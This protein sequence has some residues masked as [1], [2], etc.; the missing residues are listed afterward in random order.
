MSTFRIFYYGCRRG[1]RGDTEAGHFLYGPEPELDRIPSRRTSLPFDLA[2]LDGTFAPTGGQ[3]QS[4][5]TVHVF[6]GWT[7]LSMWDR[8]GDSRPGSSS[9]FVADGVHDGPTMLKLAAS[10]FPKVWERINT[11]A[12]I[13]FVG[14]AS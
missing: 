13:E 14:G 5:A 12:P 9:T 3:P 11:A 4:L 6:H 8:T 7:V 2:H 1:V 10:W